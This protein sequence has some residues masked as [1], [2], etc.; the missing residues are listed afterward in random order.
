MSWARS[1]I[2]IAG[3]LAG[4]LWIVLAGWLRQYRGIN[5]T[6]S[7]LLLAYIAIGIFKHLV[8]GPLR[9]PASL[10]KPS[11]YA[12]NDGLL[13][14][15]IGGSD[16]H[17]GLAIGV[18]ACLGLGWWL[19]CDRLGLLGARGRRQSAHR[20][21][22]GP[23]GHATHPRGLRARRRVRGARG[24]GRGGGGAHQR[25][26][27]ADRGLWLRGHPRVV[28]RAAQPGGHRAGGN[29]VRRLR[30]GRQPAAAAARV[31]R[32]VGA[33]AAGHR[34]RADPGER[35]PAHDRL[36]GAARARRLFRASGSPA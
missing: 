4:A 21:A 20:A 17:W 8:E 7:S 13:I 16:V 12:L 22:R 14:G 5:E 23:A 19:R 18:V 33:G 10:N 2:C 1:I 32:C 25:Q 36:E 28:H 6:I 11:T 30:R 35:G 27:L 26:R 29:P 15:G 34:L 3:A 9:D 24:R 31:A